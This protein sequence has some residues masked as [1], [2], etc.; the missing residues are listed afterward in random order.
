VAPVPLRLSWRSW[1]RIVAGALVGLVAGIVALTPDAPW[2]LR[3]AAGVVFAAGTYLVVD[4]IVFA[5]SWR[6]T[7]R[8][9]HVPTLLSRRREIVGEELTVELVGDG[10]AVLRVSGPKG[11]RLVAASPFVASADLR[12]WFDALPDE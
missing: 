11:S 2:V 1:A 7:A 6:F 8:A 4:A 3:I 10:R 12:R 9:L 5:R